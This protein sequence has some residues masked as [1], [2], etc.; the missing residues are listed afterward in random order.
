M[1]FQCGDRF[2]GELRQRPFALRFSPVFCD[3]F[4]MVFHHRLL[5]L[6]VERAAG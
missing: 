5:E 6:P 2:L 4:L 1:F 3:V